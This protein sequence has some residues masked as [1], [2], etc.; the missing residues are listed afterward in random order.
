M[1]SAPDPSAPQIW[2]GYRNDCRYFNGEKPCKWKCEGGCQHFEPFHTRIL[3]IK[4]GATG[5]VLRTTPLLRAIKAKFPLSHIT[6]LVEPI[7]APLLKN[8]PLID[9][10]LV[11]S[12]DTLARLQVEKYDVLYCLDKVDAATAVAMQVQAKEKWGF[13][14]S[15]DGN[16]SIF[17]PEAEEAL[18]L[19][20]SDEFKFRQNQKPY[21]QIVFE[22]VGFPFNRERYVLEL[23]PTAKEWAQQWAETHGLNGQ[24]VIGLNTGAGT[25]FA[26]KAWRTH[27]WAELARCIKTGLGARVV[28]LG[29]PSE[30]EKNREIAAFASDAAVDSGTDNTLPNFCALVNLCDAVVTGDTTGMHIAIALEKPVVVLFGSTCPQE[31]DLYGKGEKLVAE[32]DCAPC[33][34]KKCPIGE[35][36]MDTITVD[37]VFMALQRQI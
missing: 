22:A 32:V 18:I 34:L 33:Y 11:P 16:L 17:N 8:N 36:C 7:S 12:F 19:G 4:L 20:L 1:P 30:R 35:I 13:G 6:W 5:D 24:K 26:G 3:V 14:M 10:I 37:E 28:L 21:Q 29:G 25:G 23:E 9:K 2:G 15:D 27:S 31:I